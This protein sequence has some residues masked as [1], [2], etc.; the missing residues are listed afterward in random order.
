MTNGPDKHDIADTDCLE[1]FDHLYAYLNGELHDEQTTARLEHHLSHCKSCFSRAQMER[2]L[3]E[4][5]K[6]TGED[7]AP[8]SLR[9][10]LHNLIKDF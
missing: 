6:K 2:Q 4:R 1:A 8:E 7:A 3:N 5:L 9:N 10:R